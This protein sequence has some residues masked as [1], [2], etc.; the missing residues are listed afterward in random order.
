MIAS[1]G[2]E[3]STTSTNGSSSPRSA[4]QNHSMNSSPPTGRSRSRSAA[5]GRPPSAGPGSVPSTMSSMLG[6][7]AAVSATESPSQLSPALIHEMW[8][9]VSSAI[10]FP[11]SR[12]WGVSYRGRQHG[13]CHQPREDRRPNDHDEGPLG[14]ASDATPCDASP[15][16]VQGAALSATWLGIVRIAHRRRRS[17]ALHGHGAGVAYCRATA[18]GRLVPRE[19]GTKCR[20]DGLTDRRATRLVSRSLGSVRLRR[21]RAMAGA[22]DAIAAPIEEL[23]VLWITAA[24]AATATPSP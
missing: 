9:T 12:R 4:L 2:I 7:M 11:P 14:A 5:S 3:P 18:S 16:P 13:P 15:A 21:E 24:S 6:C 23:H 8:T 20:R 10:S 19:I 1:L 17:G 22:S